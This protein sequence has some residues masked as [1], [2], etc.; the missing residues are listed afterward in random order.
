LPFAAD[1]HPVIS[2]N[3]LN[4]NS[5]ELIMV[6]RE[7]FQHPKVGPPADKSARRRTMFP[8]SACSPAAA[9]APSLP[10]TWR[11]VVAAS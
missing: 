1:Q 9:R 6:R 8:M 7:W 4:R 3:R 10:P 11:P 2:R 5:R